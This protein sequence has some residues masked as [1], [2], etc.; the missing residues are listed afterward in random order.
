MSCFKHAAPAPMACLERD[1]PG[2]DAKP[3]GSLT[4]DPDEINDILVRTWNQVYRGNGE[5]T[6]AIAND[7]MNKYHDYIHHA[8]PWEI[9]DL[10]FNDFKNICLAGSSSAVGLDGWAAKDLALLSDKAI[11]ALVDFLN[12]IEKGA[13][14]PEHMLQTR[15]VFLSKDPDQTANPLAYRILKITSGLYRKWASCRNMNLENWIKNLGLRRHKF[16]SSW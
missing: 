10:E 14:W 6:E 13:P 1:Q 11:Q 9:G 4:S 12:E 3:K 8:K 15:A 7:F 16:R 2:A 5:D